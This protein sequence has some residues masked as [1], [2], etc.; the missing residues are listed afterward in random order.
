MGVMWGIGPRGSVPRARGRR[1][2]RAWRSAASSSLRRGSRGS[3]Y[4]ATEMVS[5]ESG[6]CMSP[7]YARLRRPAI[8]RGNEERNNE[9]DT[10][11]APPKR[12]TAWRR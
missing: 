9:A 11:G 2:L 5:A 7:G 12:N 1:A 4:R 8:E 6:F 10:Y 3:T